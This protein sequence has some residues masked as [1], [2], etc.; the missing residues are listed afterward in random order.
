M[1]E[2]KTNFALLCD[3]LD[4]QPKALADAVGTD[5]TLVSRWRTGN[6]KL[7]PG[8]HWAPKVAEY[9]MERDGKR[10]EPVIKRLL[11]VLYPQHPM[12][13]DAHQLE[14]LIGFL[15][16]GGQRQSEY[17]QR[18]FALLNPLIPGKLVPPDH[19]R[20]AEGPRMQYGVPGL[21]GT[22]TEFLATV[23]K[24]DTPQEI[25]FDCP[26]GLEMLVRDE[27]FAARAL[28]K[29]NQLFERGHRLTLC[30]R[31]EYQLLNIA[32]FT[33]R[34]LVLHLKG[35]VKSY[36]YQS[37]G[38]PDG[39]RMMAAVRGRIAFSVEDVQTPVNGTYTSLM[40]QEAAVN[41]V[42]DR[43]DAHRNAGQMR[44]RYG[45]LKQPG[46]ALSGVQPPLF[47]DSFFYADL[48]H[49]CV[50]G[51][52]EMRALFGLT[53]QEI[54]VLKRDFLPLL[55][56]PTAFRPEASVRHMFCQDDLEDMLLKNRHGAPWLSQMLG[57]QVYMTTRN[58]ALQLQTI[59]DLLKSN[60][61]YDVALVPRVIADRIRIQVGVWGSACAIGGANHLESAACTDPGLV[62]ALNS[63]CLQVWDALPAAQ[64]NRAANLRRLDTLLEK[65]RRYGV[66]DGK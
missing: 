49:C 8:R 55:T 11:S 3:L 59:R 9:L 1:S 22:V 5:T 26:Y 13:T 63:Y 23:D 45:F 19:M 37:D 32:L 53:D 21:Q 64:K 41:D 50:S 30:I 15:T 60:R 40:F 31:S 38:I 6:R 42:W 39:Q 61:N 33:G 25:L 48:P 47:A 10:A 57:R 12:A 58:L 27:V 54:E 29:L 44:I 52:E 34:W 14:L 16:E 46:G 35:Y 17:Q 56:P 24:Y 4:A 51:V 36:Y 43:A 2:T 66:Y 62:G 18:R 28:E 20:A 7:M 65:A